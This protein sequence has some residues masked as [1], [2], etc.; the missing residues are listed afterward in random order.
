MTTQNVIFR[1]TD[2]VGQ[3]MWLGFAGVIAAGLAIVSSFGLC[4]TIG[5]DFVSIVGVV[6]F[7]IM[8]KQYECVNLAYY[9]PGATFGFMLP[10]FAIVQLYS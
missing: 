8:G 1:M 4:A 10:S 9:K 6:P 2:Q 5:V 7:L 3:R